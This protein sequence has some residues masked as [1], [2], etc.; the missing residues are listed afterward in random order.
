[1][2]GWVSYGTKLVLYRTGVRNCTKPYETCT[3]RSKLYETVRN[4]DDWVIPGWN[5][6][7]SKLMLAFWCYLRIIAPNRV[8][9]PATRFRHYAF[10]DICVPCLEELTL[11]DKTQLYLT[12]IQAGEKL[13]TGATESHAVHTWHFLPDFCNKKYLMSNYL[14]LQ[15]TSANKSFSNTIRNQVNLNPCHLA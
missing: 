12:Y 11:I 14:T 4:L 2:Q 7:K 3:K 5:W 10:I 15:T 8:L 6:T 9:W 13:W 1:M